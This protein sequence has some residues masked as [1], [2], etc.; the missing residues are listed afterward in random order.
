MECMVPGVT[1]RLVAGWD[2]DLQP[3]IKYCR[4]NDSIVF[5]FFLFPS[6]HL[7]VAFQ[8]NA[9]I[10]VS[11]HSFRRGSPRLHT[12]A[13]TVPCNIRAANLF[14]CRRVSQDFDLLPSL[15]GT[16]GSDKTRSLAAL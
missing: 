14:D 5:L 4:F 1:S 8:N 15:I 7:A 13:Q 12:R 2:L 3:Y 9:M 6:F 10:D 16:S 11:S